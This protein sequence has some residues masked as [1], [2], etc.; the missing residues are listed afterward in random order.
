ML[1]L[2]IVPHK[3]LTMSSSPP[4]NDVD[5]FDDGD[6]LLSEVYRFY[7]SNGSLSVSGRGPAHDKESLNTAPASYARALLDAN[8]RLAG[9][10]ARGDLVRVH[11]A[12]LELRG[13]E[14]LPAALDEAL[15]GAVCS[16]QGLR[17][18]E[19]FVRRGLEPK[20]ETLCFNTIDAAVDA[21]VAREA[22]EDVPPSSEAPAD[23]DPVRLLLSS[24]RAA[25]D[26]DGRALIAAIV[27]YEETP[28]TSTSMSAA[29]SILWCCARCGCDASGARECDFYSPLHLA[30]LHGLVRETLALLMLG[31]DPNAVA[32]DDSTPLTAL[33]TGRCDAFTPSA[34]ARFDALEAALSEVGAVDG[35]KARLAISKPVLPA[36]S[37]PAWLEALRT[38][39]GALA[40]VGLEERV[41]GGAPRGGST[42][43]AGGTFTL[44]AGSV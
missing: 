31:A 15:S 42:L 24:E 27:T 14:L 20:R 18:A 13:G 16:G 33:R 3:L 6:Y 1:L 5:D 22:G 36:I 35:L 32:R 37:A 44:T 39:G 19:Y 11:E 25:L 28:T 7:D 2:L 34:R 29:A 4:T 41:G 30:A 40:A 10:A 17:V 43:T 26:A 8:L 12:L 23:V 21:L 38:L 9:A